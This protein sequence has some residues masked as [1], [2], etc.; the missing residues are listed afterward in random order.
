MRPYAALICE[1]RIYLALPLH[2]PTHCCGS[3]TGASAVYPLLGCRADP[4][5]RFVATGTR[6][7]SVTIR[8]HLT[9]V[10]YPEIDEQSIVHARQNAARNGLS[11]RIQVVAANPKGPIFVPLELDPNASLVVPPM[12]RNDDDQ[13]TALQV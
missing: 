6:P 9:R 5:W 10:V 12:P 3:G 13:H 8:C 11:G 7:I 4:R 1:L 2:R